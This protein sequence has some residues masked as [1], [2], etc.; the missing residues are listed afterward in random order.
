MP[1]DGAV[2]GVGARRVDAQAA[3]RLLPRLSF[4][5]D[6][7]LVDDEVMGDVRCRE[8]E[9][10]VLAGLQPLPS[11]WKANDEAATSTRRAPSAA[12]GASSCP[13]CSSAVDVAQPVSAR[14]AARTAKIARRAILARRVLGA[15]VMTPLLAERVR[16][17]GRRGEARAWGSPV[18]WSLGAVGGTRG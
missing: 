11:G 9:C 12:S 14:A 3:L 2:G 15:A 7:D 18:R 5:V 13:A 16:G 10:D 8:D 4:E 17:P 6:V 1:G